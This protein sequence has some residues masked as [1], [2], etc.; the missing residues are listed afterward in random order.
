MNVNSATWWK[1]IDV[2]GHGDIFFKGNIFCETEYIY[3]KSFISSISFLS[4]FV[5][6]RI[7]T[8]ILLPISGE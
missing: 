5:Q 4:V 1:G 3:F 7:V 2:T 6:E 8:L